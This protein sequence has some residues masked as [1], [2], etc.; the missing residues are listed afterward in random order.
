MACCL[1][2]VCFH[3]CGVGSWRSVEQP[4]SS[5]LSPLSPLGAAALRVLPPL[6]EMASSEA[7]GFLCLRQLGLW[8]WVCWAWG[9]GE[10]CGGKTA[11]FPGSSQ[12]NSQALYPCTPKLGNQ[13]TRSMYQPLSVKRH[14]GLPRWCIPPT[15]FYPNT[16]QA[17]N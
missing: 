7:Q 6:M 3:W 11:S 17:A 15:T 10:R 9:M 14:K 5:S 16:M 13:N 1:E 4:S 8:G 2:P 12:V